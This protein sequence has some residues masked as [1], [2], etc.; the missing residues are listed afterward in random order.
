MF[1][2][3]KKIRAKIQQGRKSGKRS[4]VEIIATKDPMAVISTGSSIFRAKKSKL[5]R[6]LDTVDLQEL[7]DSR[8]D[9]EPSMSEEQRQ[10]LADVAQ[11]THKR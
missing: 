6:L 1:F 7:P 2:I 5:R 10:Y 4:K 11:E 3:G 8:E 9:E